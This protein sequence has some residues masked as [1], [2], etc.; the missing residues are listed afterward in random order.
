MAMKSTKTSADNASKLAAVDATQSME[1]VF[2]LIGEIVFLKGA[3]PSPLGL[4]GVVL[5]MLGLGAY[6]GIQKK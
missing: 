1:V 4:F 2:S 5:T 6:M 3:I